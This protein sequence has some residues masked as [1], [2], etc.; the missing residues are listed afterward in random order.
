MNLVPKASFLF[1]VLS[2]GSSLSIVDQ[3]DPVPCWCTLPCKRR[4]TFP[5]LVL[6]HEFFRFAFV[7]TVSVCDGRIPC[8][9]LSCGDVVGTLVVLL[10]PPVASTLRPGA[11]HKY[12]HRWSCWSS[13]PGGAVHKH[14]HGLSPVHMRTGPP[15]SAPP[16]LKCITSNIK[17]E[18]DRG[19]G[20]DARA[21][22][23]RLTPCPKHWT[24]ELLQV[25]PF[26]I[27][28]RHH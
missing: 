10:V 9:S 5:L 19:S 27:P 11:V 7:S 1:S 21:S 3:K 24:Q 20:M 23:W 22:D 15:M 18:I 12:T 28:V 8:P 17:R 16:M 4:S 13:H 6:N 26:H 2:I 14:M 25:H